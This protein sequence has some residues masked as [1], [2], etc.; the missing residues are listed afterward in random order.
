MPLKRQGLGPDARL[1]GRKR[2]GRLFSEG[3]RIAGRNIVLWFRSPIRDAAAPQP[4]EPAR[5]GLAVSAKL[6]NA[7]LRNRLKRLAREAFR[8]NRASLKLGCDMVVYLRPGCRWTGLP[9]AE[10]DLL[11]ICRKADILE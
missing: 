5:L 7:V 1:S 11:A 4:P 2:F 10:K 8:L 9:E 3:R 6:G